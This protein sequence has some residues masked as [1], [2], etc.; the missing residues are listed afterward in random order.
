MTALL[1]SSG[2]SRND[3]NNITPTE[4]SYLLSLFKDGVL[5]GFGQ[6]K[7]DYIAYTPMPR[8]GEILMSVNS[9]GYK[10]KNPI[11][12]EEYAQDFFTFYNGVAKESELTQEEKYNKMMDFIN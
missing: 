9:K 3:I 8:L 10:A 7:R 11:N 1:L 2:V 4:S 6:C 5:G 12:F